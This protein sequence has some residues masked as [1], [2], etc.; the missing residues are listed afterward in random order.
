MKELDDFLKE[1]YKSKWLYFDGLYGSSKVYVR[2]STRL[3]EGKLRRC[4]DIGTIEID[5]Q[6]RGRGVWTR[7]TAEL[8]EKDLKPFNLIFVENVMTKRFQKWF[9]KTK[10]WQIYFPSS[11]SDPNDIS[12]SFYR[13]LSFN[14]IPQ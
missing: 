8:A 10:P 6:F 14:H 11:V 2:K 7:F 5:E 4:L 12:C 13:K 9:L 3:I 1:E